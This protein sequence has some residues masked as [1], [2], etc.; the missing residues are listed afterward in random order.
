MFA[1]HIENGHRFFVL[2][3]GCALYF[4]QTNTKELRRIVTLLGYGHIICTDIRVPSRLHTKPL[5]VI[6]EPNPNQ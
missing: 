3:Y 5:S 6:A 1:I 2:F 4:R